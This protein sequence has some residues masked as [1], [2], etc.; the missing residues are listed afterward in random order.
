MSPIRR[1]RLRLRLVGRS[2]SNQSGGFLNWWP[3]K[4]SHYCRRETKLSQAAVSVSLLLVSLAGFPNEISCFKLL[5]P[6]VR[7][8]MV[9][10]LA[11]EHQIERLMDGWMDK[12]YCWW[13]TRLTM[14]LVENRWVHRHIHMNKASLSLK[15]SSSVLDVKSNRHLNSSLCLCMKRVS[16]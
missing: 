8:E 11:K 15:V 16:E 6:V 14:M 5:L 3:H 4:T 1:L 2:K 13:V 9:N 10:H 7:W 12:Y